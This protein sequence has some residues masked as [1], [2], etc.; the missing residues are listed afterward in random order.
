[1]NLIMPILMPRHEPSPCPECGKPEDVIHVCRNCGH[2]YQA[3]SSGWWPVVRFILL[4][5]LGFIAVLWPGLTIG[6]WL[7]EQSFKKP[8][9]LDVLMRQVDFFCNLRIW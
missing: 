3:N 8:T 5:M 9:L 7:I 4:F 1:M 6:I 2:E